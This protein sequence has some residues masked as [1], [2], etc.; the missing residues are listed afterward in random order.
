MTLQIYWI[1]VELISFKHITT[2]THFFL[3]IP[4]TALEQSAHRI[5][6]VSLSALNTTDI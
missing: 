4:L 1:H 3:T 2:F 5:Q 6:S